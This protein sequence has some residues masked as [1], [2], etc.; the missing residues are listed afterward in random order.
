MVTAAAFV[1]VSGCGTPFSDRQHDV[2]ER[3]VIDAVRR[4]MRLAEQSPDYRSI[5]RDSTVQSLNIPDRRLDE[6]DELSGP[7][8]YAGV[9]APVSE[10][11]VGAEQVAVRV[12]LERAIR[13]A[14]ERN[15]ALQF[16]RL[17]PA[18]SEAQLVQ[19]LANFDWTFFVN[20][21]YQYRD[22]PRTS[23]TFFG[24]SFNSFQQ[25]DISTGLRKNT[26]TGGTLQLDTTW[27][28]SQNENPGIVVVPDPANTVTVGA[29]FT[30]PLLRGAGSDVARATI[31]VAANAER[32]SVQQLKTSLIGTVLQTE[33]AYWNLQLALESLRVQQRLL[34]R[35]ERVRDIIVN[36]EQLD[37]TQAEIADARAE[38]ES[39][40]AAVIRAERTLRQASDQLKVLINDPDLTI[41]SELLVLPADGAVDEPIRYSLADALTTAFAERPEVAQAIISLEN[42]GIRRQ[43]ARNG[44]LPRLDL[45]FETRYSAL[46][47]RP[48]DA[49]DDVFDGSFI[50]YVVGLAF[51]QPL[52]NRFANA[53][54]RE[55]QLEQM[56]AITSYQNTIQQVT[57]EVKN[58][59]RDVVTGYQ[60]IEQTR[61]ARVAAA[62]NLRALTVQIE[63]T[64]GY[65]AFNLDQWLNR[66]LQLAGAELEEA[67]SLISYNIAVARLHSVLGTTL[68]HNAIE[69][70]V[71]TRGD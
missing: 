46:G 39:R 68:T 50:D 5:T 37:A 3:S 48:N 69:F 28:W 54:L 51:E 70:D 44:I 4:E 11:L 26:T 7:A 1:L 33:E 67:E 63:T 17:A 16:Q 22:Q 19:A 55:A 52:G 59:L 47:A 25:S 8:S 6:L 65:T 35:G 71:E 20:G 62:E 2:A 64:G 10:D 32:A 36:R 9:G 34:N 58:A 66:Q 45:N 40:R 57:L 13:S 60:L 15:L 53:T 29:T 30:Q 21:Q 12:S 27:S 56:Q 49:Y 42:T 18:I 14:A 41:G 24:A 23:T 61:T 31:R 38:V 43:V